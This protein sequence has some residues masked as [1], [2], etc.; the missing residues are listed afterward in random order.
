VY[1]PLPR[2]TPVPQ[3]F[4]DAERQRVDVGRRH[5]LHAQYA[6]TQRQR[7]T[8]IADL[9]DDRRRQAAIQV[10]RRRGAV[11]AFDLV[12]V[13]WGHCSLEENEMTHWKRVDGRNS[14][15]LTPAP[16]A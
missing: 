12:P 14:A 16:I 4:A 3:H 2:P 9:G 8:G 1:R 15:A 6:N 10:D 7:V 5:E 13:R 11:D